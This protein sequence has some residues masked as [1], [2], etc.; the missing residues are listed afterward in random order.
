MQI[1]FEFYDQIDL[2]TEIAESIYDLLVTCDEEFVPSLSTRNTT[3]QIGFDSACIASD[4]Q[5]Y[6]YWVN[7]LKQKN[8]L[9]IVDGHIVGIMS[10]RYNY[11]LG[12]YFDI[13][14]QRDAINNYVSTIC[15]DKNYRGHGMGRKLYDYIE[16][17]LPKKYTS[18]YVSTRTWS[19]NK[20]HINL[21][22]KL[23]YVLMYTIANDREYNGNKLDTLYF[24]K[25]L[26]RL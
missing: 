24:V 23:S 22:Y 4:K 15:I 26:E 9:A 6:Q 12:E 20:G 18:D 5:P 25:H 11:K 8:I 2:N 7:I 17:N 3:T 1:K 13:G 21:L 14:V 19:T 16:N 10:F